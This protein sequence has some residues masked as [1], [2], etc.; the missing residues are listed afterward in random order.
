[1]PAGSGRTVFAGSCG[2]A[3]LEA[4]LPGGGVHTFLCLGFFLLFGGWL[5]VKDEYHIRPV[6][7]RR[8]S[9]SG[10]LSGGRH[11]F[12]CLSTMLGVHCVFRTPDHVMFRCQRD[13]FARI[14]ERQTTSCFGASAMYLRALKLFAALRNSRY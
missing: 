11:H 4:G 3:A 12:L 6:G 8:E 5:S 14:F 9:L 7:S 13:V 2:K 1:M 10:G